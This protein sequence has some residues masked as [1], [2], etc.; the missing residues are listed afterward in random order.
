MAW[1]DWEKSRDVAKKERTKAQ[2][3]KAVRNFVKV[4][5]DYYKKE[6][7]IARKAIINKKLGRPPK[8]PN[9]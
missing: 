9:N 8:S 1:R 2:V 3:R 6:N 7:I 5:P 4:N